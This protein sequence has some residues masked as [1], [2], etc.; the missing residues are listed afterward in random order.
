MKRLMI[1]A[2]SDGSNG[3]WRAAPLAGLPIV[4]ASISNTTTK[5]ALKIQCGLDPNTYP[6]GI[7][8]SDAEMATLDITR[9][10]F[11]PE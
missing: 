2:D 9:D 7:K 11:H 10:A 1:T 5:K 8:V 6:N 3:Y 4:I